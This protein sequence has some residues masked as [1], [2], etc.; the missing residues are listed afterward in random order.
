VEP[1]PTILLVTPL[2]PVYARLA[3]AVQQR[4]PDAATLR[5]RSGESLLVSGSRPQV[6]AALLERGRPVSSL[7][8]DLHADAVLN[9]DLGATAAPDAAAVGDVL[10]PSVVRR[11]GAAPA[12]TVSASVLAT[13]RELAHE[14]W[15]VRIVEPRPGR[16]DERPA[17]RFG[18]VLASDR[19]FDRPLVRAQGLGLVYDNMEAFGTQLSPDVAFGLVLGISDDA[20]IE[21]GDAWREYA[22]AAAGAFAVALAAALPRMGDAPAV[23]FPQRELRAGTQL[24]RVHRGAVRPLRGARG[25]IVFSASAAAALADVI[26]PWSGSLPI[27][28]ADVAGLRLSQFTLRSGLRVADLTVP[29]TRLIG[30]DQARRLDERGIEMVLAAGLDGWVSP[31]RLS[32][33]PAWDHIA[34]V[35]QDAVL[36]EIKEVRSVG[37]AIDALEPQDPVAQLLRAAV[38][39]S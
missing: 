4:Y 17:V 10:V 34:V 6:A 31:S 7:I 32:A 3:D 18:D 9:V 33:D 12:I 2:E 35:R 15:A 19:V 21:K 23:P 5:V 13:A 14:S 39:L 25:P 30:I 29:S 24:Y 27:T 1:A 20:S 16:A 38:P 8:A 11:P 37:D 28:Q 22:S 36:P 26:L